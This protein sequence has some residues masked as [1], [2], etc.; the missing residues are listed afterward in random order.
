M[1]KTCL[2]YLS[3]VL[4]LPFENETSHFILYNA[5]LEYFPLYQAWCET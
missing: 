5:L 4:T 1:K 2:P 3:N